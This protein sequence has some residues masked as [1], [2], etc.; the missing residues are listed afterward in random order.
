MAAGA[1][2]L[3]RGSPAD[4]ILCTSNAYISQ[5]LVEM[6]WALLYSVGLCD[7]RPGKDETRAAV[8]D[9]DR[10]FL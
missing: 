7:S 4:R 3:R 1:V 5:S 9:A 8:L 2:A 6:M 10:R